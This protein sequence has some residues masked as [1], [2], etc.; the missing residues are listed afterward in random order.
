M[1][2]VGDVKKGRG[3]KKKMKEEKKSDEPSSHEQT[4]TKKNNDVDLARECERR[5]FISI[6]QKRRLPG[7]ES[8]SSIIYSSYLILIPLPLKPHLFPNKKPSINLI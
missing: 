5:G 6:W 1:D 8:F 7:I 4:S 2:F 3:R